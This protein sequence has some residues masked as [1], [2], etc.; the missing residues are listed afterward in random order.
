MNDLFPGMDLQKGNGLSYECQTLRGN[1]RD[2]LP[3]GFSLSQV[4]ED[5][6]SR[7]ELRNLD[8][9][10]AEMCSERPTVE[11]F[12]ARSFG[13]CLLCGNEIAGWCLSKYDCGDRCEVGIETVEGYRRRGLGTLMS[14]ALV[15]KAL[16]CRI[17][18]VG[19]HCSSSN[20]A[21]A[22]TVLRS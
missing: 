16:S 15:E 6:L 5:L 4:N 19:W 10:Q 21:S 13:I 11:E 2:H 8:A 22:A 9:L 20:K 1:W 7:S 3:I 12:L 17:T 14:L 18:R